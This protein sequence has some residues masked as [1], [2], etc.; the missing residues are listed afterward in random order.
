MRPNEKIAQVLLERAL[1]GA[2]AEWKV[3]QSHGEWDFDLHLDGAICPVEVTQATSQDAEEFSAALFGK[4]GVKSS[5]PRV[6]SQGCWSVTVS[7]LAKINTVRKRL[8]GLLADLETTGLT[9]FS[10]QAAEAMGRPEVRA[11]WE[12]IRVTDGFRNPEAELVAH[13]LMAPIDSAM[14]ASDQVV[15]A[16]ER[17]VRKPDNRKKLGRS[18]ATRRHLFVH[19]AYDCYPAFE[20]MSQCGLPHSL[21]RLP[22]EVTHVWAARFMGETGYLLWSFDRASAWHSYGVVTSGPVPPDA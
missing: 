18:A 4:G 14:L 22:S 6:R 9:S 12:E 11:L 3:S 19:I 7:R 2:R 21:V 8:D 13:Q 17:E 20:A 16:L 5:V 1:P 15:A 10:V